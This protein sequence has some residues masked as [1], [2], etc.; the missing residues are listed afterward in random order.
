MKKKSLFLLL[1][2]ILIFFIA[3]E[4]RSEQKPEWKSKIERENGVKV[5]KNPKVPLYG[6]IK[7]ELEEDLSIG[8]D[9]D[10]NY[11]FYRIRDVVVD[12]EGNIFVVDM[13]NFRI[14]IFDSNG[15]CLNTI[16]RSGQ[17]P[18]EF[19]QPSQIRINNL[20]GE[21]YVKDKVRALDVFNKKGEFIE[22]IKMNYGIQDFFPFEDNTILAILIKP[23]YEELTSMHVLCKIDNKGEILM[24]LTEFPYTVFTKRVSGGILSGITGYELSLNFAVL[25]NDKI[26]YGYSKEY[27][28]EVIDRDGKLLYKIK[29]DSPKPKFTSDELSQFKKIPVPKF[30]PYFYS[31]FSDTEGR[32]YVQRNQARV[33]I[34]GYG[35]IDK[36]NKEVDIFSKDGYFLYKATLPPNT[37]IIKD[38]FLYARDLDEEGGME[39]VKRYKIKNGEQMKERI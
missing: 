11:M 38:E 7:F 26:V 30:K 20:T 19:E 34:R 36:M 1:N 28:L 39:Y 31:I 21:I 27:E 10:V 22:S 12:S 37:C 3:Y 17:G 15:K 8:R 5:I 23:P 35:P 24:S 25:N 29:K 32:I 33:T 16:G 18:G 9:D 14:Q 2:S 4:S 13:S 6:E